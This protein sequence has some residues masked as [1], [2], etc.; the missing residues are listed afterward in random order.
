MYNYPAWDYAAVS[1]DVILVK[2]AEDVVS[3]RGTEPA[4]NRWH[5]SPAV[6]FSDLPLRYGDD[7]KS[8]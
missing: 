3:G 4:F 5:Q 2:S 1:G 6:W 7:W 8:C